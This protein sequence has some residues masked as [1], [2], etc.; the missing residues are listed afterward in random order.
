MG[1]AAASYAMESSGHPLDTAG[2]NVSIH[3]TAAVADEKFGA[4]GQWVT[5]D[6]LRGKRVT[7]S[8]EI[9]TAEV[10]GGASLWMRFDHDSEMLW[11]DNGGATAL[12]GS[13]EWTRRNV[14]FVVPD[15]ATAI[16]VGMIVRGSGSAQ[17]RNL[18]LQVDPLPK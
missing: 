14:S 2:A 17:V 13:E 1:N 9:R 4:A 11:L 15:K 16:W 8:G 12:R 7:L 6:G 18:K 10:K 5:P 3:S